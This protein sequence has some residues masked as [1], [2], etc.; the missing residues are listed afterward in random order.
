MNTRRR[1]FVRT[2]S[3][4]PLVVATLAALAFGAYFGGQEIGLAATGTPY[5]AAD[6]MDARPEV[7]DSAAALLAANDCWTDEAPAGVVPGHVVVTVDGQPQLGGSHMT[8][9]ALAQLFDGADHG[10]TI[11]GFCS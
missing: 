6:P 4:L 1:T 5:T 3:A 9:Q 11:H 2:M 10:L 7:T 8:G